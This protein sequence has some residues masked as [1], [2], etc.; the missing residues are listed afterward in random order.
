MVKTEN[1]EEVALLLDERQ[2]ILNKVMSDNN[3]ALFRQ[4]YNEYNLAEIDNDINMIFTESLESAKQQII[5]HKKT[6]RASK[7]YMNAKKE[8]IHLFSMQG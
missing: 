3:I 7:A 2:D 4:I 6:Q 5:E 8:K 1:Q